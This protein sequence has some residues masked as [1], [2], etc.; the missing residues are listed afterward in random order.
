MVVA[1]QAAVTIENA[2]LYQQGRHLAVLQERQRF[3]RELHDSVSQALYGIVL[4]AKTTK[5]LLE[6]ERDPLK[7][8][9]PLDY[10][11]SL[12]EAALHEM[13]AL[14]FELRPESLEK[15][16][17]LTAIE[18]QAQVL[19][20]RFGLT[21]NTSWNWSEETA[22]ALLLQEVLYRVAQEATHNITKHAAAKNVDIQLHRKEQA[23]VLEVRDDGKGFN[24]QDSFPGHLGLRSMQERVEQVGGS[25][26]ID[27]RP[28]EG[29][30]IQA[31]V[32]LK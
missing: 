29:T 32:P 11:L 13:R 25:L 3:A 24:H 22:L 5:T 27:S 21:V 9:E 12:S 28:G 19:R 8:A 7:A 2:K 20:S 30:C 18:K 26:V 4:G 17:L 14:I 6:R 16:G 15:E 31:S 1:N 23:I 10:I